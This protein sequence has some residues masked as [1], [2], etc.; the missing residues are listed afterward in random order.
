MPDFV[1]ARSMR[2]ALPMPDFVINSRISARAW[3]GACRVSDLFLSMPRPH[4]GPSFDLLARIGHPPHSY[5]GF[6]LGTLRIHVG[7]GLPSPARKVP[8]ACINR[9]KRDNQDRRSVDGHW[10]G[11]GGGGENTFAARGARK[12]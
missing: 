11:G 7:F 3:V 5:G 9:D 8:E 12:M 2:G 4:C 1:N 6:G 10:G